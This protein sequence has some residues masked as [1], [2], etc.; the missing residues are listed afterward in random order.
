MDKQDFSIGFAKRR[1]LHNKSIQPQFIYSWPKSNIILTLPLLPTKHSVS[2]HEVA[3]PRQKNII[4]I[5]K[6][7]GKK[8]KKIIKKVDVQKQ[9]QITSSTIDNMLGSINKFKEL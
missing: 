1:N 8:S 5:I 9:K 7:Q 2:L 3:V 6:T 4:K